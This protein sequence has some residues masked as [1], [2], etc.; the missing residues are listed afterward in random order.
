MTVKTAISTASQSNKKPSRIQDD[1]DGFPQFRELIAMRIANASGTVFETA[2][3]NPSINLYDEFTKRLPAASRQHYNCRCCRKF[4]NDFGGL[5][6]I[7][8][9]FNIVPLLWQPLSTPAFF[10]K[11]ANWMMKE[12]SNST[13][14]GVFL[15]SADTLG[16][17]KSN[18]WTHLFGDNPAKYKATTLNA[19]QK[20]AEKKEDYRILR[21]NTKYS[22]HT[23]EQAVAVLKS[24]RLWNAS[25]QLS[26]AEWLLNIYLA[27]AQ[28]TGK[29]RDNVFWKAAANAPAGFCHFGSSMLGTLL[30]DIANRV[31]FDTI[32]A[33]WN[34]KADPARYQRP[35]AVA[36][37]T[38]N[39][40]EQIFEKLNL[41]DS[42]QR[43]YA[44]INEIRATWTP[45]RANPVRTTRGGFFGTVNATKG[46]AANPTNAPMQISGGEI[47]WKKFERDVLPT[48]M[49]IDF[50]TPAKKADFFAMTTAAKADAE[51]IIAWDS[52]ERRNPFAWYVIMG[53]SY[54]SQWCLPTN[55]YVKVTA[56][57]KPPCSWDKEYHSFGDMVLFVLEGCQPEQQSSSASI[58]P[59]IVRN[60]LHSIRS[61]IEAKS[62]QGTI[63]GRMESSANG[64]VV[65]RNH[66]HTFRVTDRNG[67]QTTY[68]IDRFE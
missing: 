42:M 67:N 26:N 65:G 34:E 66:K 48:A 58:F 1:N 16:T 20:A 11:A 21:E 51:P 56:I 24:G 63:S 35:T 8:N 59:E 13:I 49:A 46:P 6:V 15:S 64:V 29:Q 18:G 54:P 22:T 28:E 40:A 62:N 30:D 60:D 44:R 7:D 2:R 43:R 52:K 61:V 32:V 47:T 41:A 23:V 4:I 9:A 45:R 19:D 17:P 5:A 31:D 10:R 38:I 33:K 14:S 50:L 36:Q 68:T 37:G 55:A 3:T 12:V 25:K 27:F 39:Q 53:G 57:S